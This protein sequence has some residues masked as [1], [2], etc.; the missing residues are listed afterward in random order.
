VWGYALLVIAGLWIL[1][2]V[3]VSFSSAGGT[4]FEVAVYDAAI[5]PPVIAAVGLYGVLPYHGVECSIWILVGIALGLGAVTAGV[6]RL[7]EELGDRPLD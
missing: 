7:A 5:Y 6:I 3:Y 4:Q 1:Y 2:K